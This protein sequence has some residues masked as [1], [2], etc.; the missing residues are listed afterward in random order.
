MKKSPSIQG[1]HPTEHSS[2]RPRLPKHHLLNVSLQIA[3]KL[4]HLKTKKCTE[5]W[6]RSKWLVTLKLNARDSVAFYAFQ[7]C[8]C[9]KRILKRNH[10]LFCIFRDKQQKPSILGLITRL[11]RKIVPSL[12]LWIEFKYIV[13]THLTLQQMFVSIC[14][15]WVIT[16]K[17]ISHQN[18][19]RHNTYRQRSSHYHKNVW[20]AHTNNSQ[21][22]Q[23]TGTKQQWRFSQSEFCDL[24]ATKLGLQAVYRNQEYHEEAKIILVTRIRD[25]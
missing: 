18:G 1:F 8:L 21:Q 3:N 12:D 9:S 25:A 13:Y 11:C 16:L 17:H 6:P 24:M 4:G 2:T 15:H 5:K 7:T 23:R 14:L 22:C 10:V 20:P 19:L